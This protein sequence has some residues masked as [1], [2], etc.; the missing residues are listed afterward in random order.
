[1]AFTMF[2]FKVFEKQVD[3]AD[4]EFVIMSLSH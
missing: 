4:K 3:A 1:M 2:N